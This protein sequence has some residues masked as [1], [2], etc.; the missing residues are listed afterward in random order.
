MQIYLNDRNPL[1]VARNIT[2]LK[3]ISA[4]DF[5]PEDDEDFDFLWDVWYN[6]EWPEV[7]HKRFQG[8]LKDL[9]NDL[10]PENVS[11]PKTSQAEMLKKVWSAWLSVLSKT[12]SEA[13]V[14]MEKVGSER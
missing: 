1:V 5:N 8:V 9:L 13:R 10:Y 6:L 2:I 14:L 3:I 4:P 7:T 12:E 11:V